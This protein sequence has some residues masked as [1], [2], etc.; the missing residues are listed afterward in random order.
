MKLEEDGKYY[1]DVEPKKELEGEFLISIIKE[2][3]KNRNTIHIENI[4]GK[5]YFIELQAKAAYIY[6]DSNNKIE[7]SY[8]PQKIEFKTENKAEQRFIFSLSQFNQ[9]LKYFGIKFPWSKNLMLNEGNLKKLIYYNLF[10][11]KKVTIEDVNI[12]HKIKLDKKENE[13][14]SFLENIKSI[15]KLKDLSNYIDCYLKNNVDFFKYEEKN[16]IDENKYKIPMNTNFEIYDLLGRMQFIGFLENISDKEYFF[17]GPNSIGKTFTLLLFAN[18]NS[19]KSRKA[20]FNLEILNKNKQYFE[21][22]AYESRHLF[23]DNKTWEKAFISINNHGKRDPLSIISLLIT[24]VSSKD[25]ETKYFFILDHIKFHC[26]NGD[27][28]E[29]QQIMYIRQLIAQTQNCILIGCCSINYKGI[30]DILFRN[31]F[32]FDNDK[33]SIFLNYIPTFQKKNKIF[34]DY[35]DN[36]YLHI[37]G[38][39]PRFIDIRENLDKKVLNVLT[40]EI[41]EKIEKFYNKDKLLSISNL[42]KIEINKPFENWIAFKLFLENIPFKYFIINN[43]DS[44]VDYTFPLVKIAVKE[45]IDTNEIA[46][47]NSTYEEEKCWN[48]ERIVIDKIKTTH[49]FGDYYIDNY[50]EIPTIY[51]KYKIEDEL[52]SNSENILFYFTYFNVRRYDC[53]IYLY[54][55]KELILIQIS[56]NLVQKQIEKYKL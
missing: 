40:K 52:F 48:F 25:P 6:T 47:F 18:Y 45:L 19:K 39:L 36:K 3:I 38:Y 8:N 29:F 10:I 51:R 15:T 32:S 5:I 20:Y 23:D 42:K 55:L 54:E 56:K 9:T 7:I 12:F 31:W 27:D 37:L 14:G 4:S 43:E 34:N 41:K 13:V 53:A 49:V 2:L 50:I 22:L 16:F 46:H 17:T 28:I 11:N 1:F 35:K 30:K 26:L 33:E 44:S 24:L 21:I